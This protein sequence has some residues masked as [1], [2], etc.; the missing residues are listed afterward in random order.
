MDIIDSTIED[1]EGERDLESSI[2]KLDTVKE[3]IKKFRSSGLERGGEYS[4]ENLVFK[5]LRR[6]NYIQK[7]FDNKNQIIDKTLSIQEKINT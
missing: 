6:N 7:L 3:K 2:S 1:I 5:F 4:Y